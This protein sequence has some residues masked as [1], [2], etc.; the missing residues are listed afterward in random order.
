MRP[1]PRTLV[2]LQ[3]KMGLVIIGCA[4]VIMAISSWR[5]RNA[6][7]Q[8]T[9][10]TAKTSEIRGKI[11][12][13]KKDVKLLESLPYATLR[14]PQLDD[15]PA[16]VEIV[17]GWFTHAGF[18]VSIRWPST[19]VPVSSMFVTALD[20]N[21]FG[22]VPLTIAV[23]NPD[24]YRCIMSILQRA[25]RYALIVTSVRYSGSAL[26]VSARIFCW[27]NAPPAGTAYAK[28]KQHGGALL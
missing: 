23:S 3:I 19:R 15:V 20:T 27:R 24:C 10:L 25:K 18:H 21:D 4:V 26:T 5:V 7:R 12:K 14:L 13:L 28:Q 16:I 17:R 22:Y 2:A 6:M 11:K 8:A 1:S 9:L